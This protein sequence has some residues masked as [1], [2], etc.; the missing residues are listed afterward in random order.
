MQT[1]KSASDWFL[2]YC[3]AY[4]KLSPHTLKAYRH[5][6]DHLSTFESSTWSELRPS[7]L[8]RDKTRRWLASMNDSSPRTIR[9]RLATVKSLF[10]TLERQ[11]SISENPLSGMRCEIKVGLCLPRAVARSTVK[12]LLQAVRAQ[13]AESE[14]A[15]RRKL[16]EVAIIELLFATGVRVSEAVAMNLSD[17]EMDRVALTIRGKGNREREIPIVCADFKYAMEQH[18][19]QR[20]SD[21]AKPCDPLFVNRNNVRISDQSIRAILRR[22]SP[23]E[24]GIRVTPH[25]LRHTLAT[26]LLEEGADLRHI[27]KLLGHSSITTTTLYTHVS[28][29]SQRHALEK[30][31]PRNKMTP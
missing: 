13:E 20:K 25:M 23:K 5:D 10:S 17:V 15:K 27:Q 11:G 30:Y 7:E 9:R 18:L 26:L 22:Y 21:A 28:E 12:S 16:H 6:L 8:N 3:A 29:R 2:E 4:R 1:L 31:H 14:K 24:A 19:A